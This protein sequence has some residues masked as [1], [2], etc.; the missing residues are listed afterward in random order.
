MVTISHKNALHRRRRIRAWL[1]VG[2]YGW[3]TPA[4]KRINEKRCG[5][6]TTGRSQAPGAASGVN[7]PPAFTRMV[8]GVYESLDEAKWALSEISK[9]LQENE[10][11]LR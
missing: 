4:S 11:L 10:P 8:Y 6:P 3:S 5:A 1:T 2:W 9:K 7:E